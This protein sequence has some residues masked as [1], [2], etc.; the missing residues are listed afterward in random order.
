MCIKGPESWWIDEIVIDFA[1]HQLSGPFISTISTGKP[2]Q[3]FR[4]KLPCFRSICYFD[5]LSFD[6]F[7]WRGKVQL[8]A[9]F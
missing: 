1:I 9:A 7:F 2:A 6:K 4:S 8:A 5:L 3:D